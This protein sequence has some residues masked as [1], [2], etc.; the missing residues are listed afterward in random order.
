MSTPPVIGPVKRKNCLTETQFARKQKLRKFYTVIIFCGFL[1]PLFLY[2]MDRRDFESQS[3]YPPVISAVNAP[4][5]H[6]AG[7]SSSVVAQ[8]RQVVAAF[9][10][11]GALRLE[12]RDE[13]DNV[14]YI[15]PDLWVQM[16]AEQKQN[17]AASLS[18]ECDAREE[19]DHA[20]VKILDM[21]SAKKLATWNYGMLSGPQFNVY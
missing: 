13:I 8:A 3:S 1:V 12:A 19:V 15:D 18:F 17:L 5:V 21:Q 4:V 16:D 11:K 6:P 2:I 7:I 9:E 20:E 14:A 10:A